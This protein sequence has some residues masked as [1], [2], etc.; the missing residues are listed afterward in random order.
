MAKA[1]LFK[2]ISM[3]CCG[4]VQ[5]QGEF[6]Q[7]AVQVRRSPHDVCALLDDSEARFTVMQQLSAIQVQQ[8]LCRSH[9]VQRD[10]K[11]GFSID[12]VDSRGHAFKQ[13]F[14]PLARA[15]CNGGTEYSKMCYV[16]TD[17]TTPTES[18]N[19]MSLRDCWI[20]HGSGPPGSCNITASAN[21]F[22][23]ATCRCIAG[24]V[25]RS[26]ALAYDRT[27]PEMGRLLENAGAV[28]GQVQVQVQSPSALALGSPLDS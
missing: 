4:S 22:C 5:E 27:L 12:G 28:H 15:S 24:A 16:T 18:N 19:F 23:M 17:G 25:K 20:V 1:A 13:Y 21:D 26:T 7:G 3:G 14:T 8:G 2:R 11:G 10:Q 6:W 9:T